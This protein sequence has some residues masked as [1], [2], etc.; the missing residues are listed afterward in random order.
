MPKS[1]TIQPLTAFSLPPFAA[2]AVIKAAYDFPVQTT[3]YFLLVNDDY[4]NLATSFCAV[5]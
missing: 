2:A 3:A 4:S 5:F 1:A